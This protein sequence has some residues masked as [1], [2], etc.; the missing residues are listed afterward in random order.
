MRLDTMARM[1]VAIA[2]YRS[3][4]FV[5]IPPYTFNPEPDAVYLELAL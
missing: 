4:G 3:L 5:D 2:L 1:S